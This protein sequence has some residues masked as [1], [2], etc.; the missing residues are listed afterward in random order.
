MLLLLRGKLFSKSTITTV[1]EAPLFLLVVAVALLLIGA[2][3]L[4]HQIWVSNVLRH[5]TVGR[6]HLSV[7]M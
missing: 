3:S 1:R 5:A 6:G 7:I 4:V 2:K